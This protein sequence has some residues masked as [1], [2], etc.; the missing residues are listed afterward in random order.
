MKRWIRQILIIGF[1][2]LMATT[3]WAT[4]RYE[5]EPNNSYSTGKRTYDGDNNYGDNNYQQ[6]N[7]GDYNYQQGNYGY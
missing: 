1:T 2:L 6:E 4:S 3:V 7:Y 5:T